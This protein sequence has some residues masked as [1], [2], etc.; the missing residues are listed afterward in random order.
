[1]LETLKGLGAEITV[2]S[3]RTKHVDV[4]EV[5]REQDFST[6]PAPPS[7]FFA[8][9]SAPSSPRASPMADDEE[10]KKL[11]EGLEEAERSRIAHGAIFFKLYLEIHMFNISLLIP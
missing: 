7:V 4:R 2:W 6:F 3:D 5:V 8:D 9:E 11:C 1:M 10:G